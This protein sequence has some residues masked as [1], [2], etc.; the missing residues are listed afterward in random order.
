MGGKDEAY[1]PFQYH[2]QPKSKGTLS[3]E[4]KTHNNKYHM[5][6]KNKTLNLVFSLFFLILT[7]EASLRRAMKR[8]SLISWI[9][10]GIFISG[11]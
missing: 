6:G 4:P 10:L 7:E 11:F 3:I 8:N 9:C 5:F 1:Q 2:L